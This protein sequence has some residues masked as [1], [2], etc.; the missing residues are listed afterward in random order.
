MKPPDRFPGGRSLPRCVGSRRARPRQPRRSSGHSGGTGRTS[1]CAQPALLLALMTST[2]FRVL[3]VIHISS[4]RTC[5]FISFAHLEKTVF[6][7]GAES[8]LPSACRWF[9]GGVVGTHSLPVC[10][11][12]FHFP[13]NAFEGQFLNFVCL[14]YHSSL[15]R[16]S[17]IEIFVYFK[18]TKVFLVH[19]LLVVL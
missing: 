19:F 12:S 2:S 6:L 11:S 16:A 5:L 9:V 15:N 13:K 10:C 17:G 18:I 14:I 8:S 1:L 4:L 7:V 3:V